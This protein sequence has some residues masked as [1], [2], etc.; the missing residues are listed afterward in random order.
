[1]KHNLLKLIYDIRNRGE[2]MSMGDIHNCV[3]QCPMCGFPEIT[4][5][6]WKGDCLIIGKSCTNSG[7]YAYV[8]DGFTQD[9]EQP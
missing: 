9:K 2:G 5:N 3:T 7:C 1:M 6:I 4:I 8:K